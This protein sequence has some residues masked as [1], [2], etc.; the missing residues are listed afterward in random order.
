MSYR[1]YIGV[2]VGRLVGIEECGRDRFRNVLWRCKCDCGNE[3]I[4]SSAD[5][6]RT[7]SCGCLHSEVIA[8]RNRTHN[9][10]N[11][12]LY[13]VWAGIKQRCCNG[14]NKRYRDYGGRGIELFSGWMDFPAFE[15]WAMENGYREG[16]DIDRI[17]N[18]SGYFPW[19]CRFVTRQRNC[20]NKRD[21]LYLEYNGERKP[22]DEWC[23]LM[24]ISQDMVWKRLK[25]G[26]SVQEALLLP[27]GARK[28]TLPPEKLAGMMEEW[29]CT[30]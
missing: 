28:S 24:G 15:Q 12:K 3:T 18:D 14:K 30:K 25:R 22:M 1:N 17:N 20:W 23:D 10:S 7:R 13:K 5:L 26:W 6:K 29:G 4:V 27:R 21:T 8:N 11:T 19:N 16:L 2:R 9:H